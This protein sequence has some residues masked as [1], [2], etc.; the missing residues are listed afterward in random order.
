MQSQV[1]VNRYHHTLSGTASDQQVGQPGSDAGKIANQALMRLSAKN[2]ELLATEEMLRVQI[3]EYQICRQLLKESD[4]RFRA[5]HEASFGGIFVHDDG[6]ILECNQGLSEITGYSMRELIG[7]NAI[8]LVP[9]EHRFEMNENIRNNSTDSYEIEGVRKDGSRYHLKIRGKSISYNGGTARVSDFRDITE[10]K[11]AEDERSKMEQQLHH[12]QKLESLGLLAGGIAHDFNNILTLILGH[13]F[14]A[15]ESAESK[16]NSQKRFDSIENAANRAADLC[17]LMLTYAGKSTLEQTRINLR[18]LVDENVMML[19]SAIRKNVAFELELEP[20]IPLITGDIAQ[21]QQIIMNLIINAADAIGKH[22]NGT[23]RLSLSQ[24]VI[25]ARFE[26]FD[27]SG[28]CIPHGEYCCLEVSDTGCGMDE[29]AQKRIFEP[30]FTTKPAGRGLGMSA[31]LGIIKAHKGA[32]HLSSEPGVGTTFTLF[33]P[34][35]AAQAS[36]AGITQE[37][38]DRFAWLSGTVLLVEDEEVLRVIGTEILQLMGFSVVT[39]ANG[40]DALEIYARRQSEINVVLLDLIMPVMGGSEVYQALRTLSPTVPVII[41]SGYDKK[42]L[43]NRIML[44]E[45]TRFLQKPYKTSDLRGLLAEILLT[46]D[47]I[48]ESS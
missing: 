40:R 26:Q 23:I 22:N 31:V 42:E 32:L 12:A 16:E 9:Q 19:Q 46:V 8:E 18:R 36:A 27:Y 15:R 13:C 24:S 33:F 4:E 45:N 41:C 3:V 29:T 2:D 25:A 6:I 21:I 20:D 37:E 39:A 43:E 11:R 47:S 10:R 30:F 1:T 34:L 14:L 44:D 17:R 28:A 35:P 38:T 48:G 5:L 7:M